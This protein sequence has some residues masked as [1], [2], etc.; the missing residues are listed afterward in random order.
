MTPS[1]DSG[2]SGQPSSLQSLLQRAT[3]AVEMHGLNRDAII[4]QVAKLLVVHV[5]DIN[6]SQSASN[7]EGD[8][9]SA[10]E[11]RSWC[12]KSL[13]VQVWVMEI[14]SGK[15]IHDLTSAVLGRQK[16]VSY[17]CAEE[18]VDVSKDNK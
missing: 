3:S 11:L 15:S 7:Y 8:S 9:L 12:A 5:E 17:A 10:V 4:I 18:K 16:L 14:L 1:K 2:A 13:D 6:A